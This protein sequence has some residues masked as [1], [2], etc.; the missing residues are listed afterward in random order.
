M[1]TL[2]LGSTGMI[3][4]N[5]LKQL[6]ETGQKP[7]L[8]VR[9]EQK[10]R[11]VLTEMGL[12]L[13][14]C[15]LHTGDVTDPASLK[16]AMQGMELVYHAAGLP[17]QWFAD[18]DIFDRVNHQGTRNVLEA[19][20]QTSVR[21]LVYTSTI[22][23]FKAN[24]GEEYTEA[25]LDP[26]PRGTHYERSK[27]K[28]DEAAV[29][30]LNNGLDIVF[31]HPS[32]LY[33]P[34]PLTSPGSNDFIADLINGK[35][36][37]LLPGGFPIVFSEDCARGHILAAEKA[38]SGARFILS[39]RYFSLKDLAEAVKTLRPELKVPGIMPVW[40]ARLFSAAGE[41]KARLTKRSPMLPAGQ[42]YFLLWQAIP[43]A[44]RANTQLGWQVTPTEEGLE[45]TI[46][47]LRM[48]G[49]IR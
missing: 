7:D 31:T 32:G 47:F 46:A 25:V 8:L 1:K 13:T 10:A 24:A 9:N 4:A 3:G 29:E 36:P 19:A 34:G 48:N 15:A 20:R 45:K 14:G 42:L 16:K 2:I 44:E 27:Q 40:F 5:I 12:D 38:A 39:D 49:K 18:P 26:K 43:L 35:V 6:L 17:E 33:G 37:M 30:A 21:R 22:D 11:K 41:V 23:V 28:A